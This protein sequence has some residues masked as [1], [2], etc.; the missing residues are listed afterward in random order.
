[1]VSNFSTGQEL[2]IN[3]P[4]ITNL[5]HGYSNSAGIAGFIA[6]IVNTDVRAGKV[7][8]FGKESFA[9]MDLARAPGS[10][11]QRV[12]AQFDVEAFFLEQHAIGS[13]VAR[14]VYE[15]AVNGAAR[16]DLRSQA[17]MRAAA[18][19]EQSWEARVV[20]KVYAT[21]A[22]ETANVVAVNGAVVDY[23]TL[24]Q[25]AQELVRAQIGRYA[26]S[27]VIAS[28][29][30]RFV[31]RNA[32]YRDRIKY[33]SAA[34]VNSEMISTW[35]DLSRGVRTA[36]RQKLSPTGALVDMV[37]SGSILL[38][39]NPEDAE[40]D[41]FTASAQSD[42]SQAAFAYTY[43]LSGYPIAEEERFDSDRKVFVTDLIAE[44]SI[45]LVGLGN[46]GKC[47]AAVL[48]TGINS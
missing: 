19:L 5:I 4:V 27:A 48:L 28:D 12:G 41:G 17:A 7:I 26:N 23:D 44:Q 24:I 8:K 31:R 40:S 22:Y 29:V 30:Y 36:M 39:Y 42:S 2:R 32:A 16:I 6:P 9:V 33:T 38:F 43:Q 11:I 45:Q 21:A 15:E 20:E 37:P 25:D 10:N 47:G 3:D 14:E 1:M 34:S 13:E 35:W 18:L 46:T